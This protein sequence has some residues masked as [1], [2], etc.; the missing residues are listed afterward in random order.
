M[1]LIGLTGPSGSGKSRVAEIFSHFGLPILNAD[2]IYHQLLIPPS[3]CLEALVSRFGAGILTAAGTLNR[4]VLADIVFSDP[5]SLADLNEISHR[6][7]M[8]E[9][10]RRTELLRREETRAA[11]LDAPQLFEAG[12]NRMCGVVVSVLADKNLRLERILQRD[13]IDRDAAMRRISAQKSDE[14]FRTHSDY[15]I[16]NNH[17]PEHII[18]EVRKI[19]T[20]TG[21]LAR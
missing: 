17:T 2:E 6:Y 18:P 13:G 16:E 1:L 19:L 8:E 11:V 4:R 7:V 15:V 14:F 12:A 10:V 21:V 5:A 20:E 9:I 3:P